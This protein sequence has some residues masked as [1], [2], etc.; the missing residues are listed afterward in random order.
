[1]VVGYRILGFRIPSTDFVSIGL[2]VRRFLAAS[3]LVY[4]YFPVGVEQWHLGNLYRF[5]ILWNQAFI[6]KTYGLK[7]PAEKSRVGKARCIRFFR[8]THRCT[9]FVNFRSCHTG[10]ELVFSLWQRTKKLP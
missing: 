9:H 1:V 10:E 6:P 3:G 7:A 5:I 2:D 8:D 4:I